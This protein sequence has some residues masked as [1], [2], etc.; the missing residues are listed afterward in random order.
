VPP[1]VLPPWNRLSSKTA[2]PAGFFWLLTAFN[3]QIALKDPFLLVF[4]LS[5]A[6][7][8]ITGTLIS[9]EAHFIPCLESEIHMQN[10]GYYSNTEE[11]YLIPQFL[12][13]DGH[14]GS[15]ILHKLKIL[16]LLIKLQL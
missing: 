1:F 4:I 9:E 11:L 14:L 15:I 2:C 13:L 10:F 7:S 8:K 6:Q 12:F 16:F 3:L 5:H